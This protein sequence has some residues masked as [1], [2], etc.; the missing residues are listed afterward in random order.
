M[1]DI[2]NLFKY[3]KNLKLNI[4]NN[5]SNINNSKFYKNLKNIYDNL[6]DINVKI[7]EKHDLKKIH[8]KNEDFLLHILFKKLQKL[9]LLDSMFKFVPDLTKYNDFKNWYREHNYLI[10]FN[11]IENILIRSYDDELINLKDVIFTKDKIRK[12]LHDKLYSNS[13]VG[14][15]TYEEYECSDLIYEKYEE[16][17]LN[18]EIIKH[19]ND[20]KNYLKYILKIISF[21]RE[22]A[23]KYN[24][25]NG[26]LNII[27]FLGETSKKLKINSIN[28]K[29][30]SSDNVNSGSCY[31]ESSIII[32]RKEEFLKVLIHELIHFHH[33]DFGSRDNN[34]SKLKS[35]LDNN[36]KLNGMDAV[37]ESYTE[38]VTIVIHEYILSRL[39]KIDFNYLLELEIKFIYFQVCKI[40][41]YYNGKSMNDLFNIDF[42]QNTSI[43]SYY[44]IKYINL[45]N[46]NDFISLVDK[47][48][49]KITNNIDKYVEYLQIILKKKNYLCNESKDLIE[50]INFKKNYTFDNMKMT[51]FDIFSI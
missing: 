15:E 9:K 46:L 7:V 38:T 28:E 26:K 31:P 35:L 19:K 24:C 6:N 41:K 2:K 48:K 42:L 21:M 43:R 22:L 16:S 12:N 51:L 10:N 1:S 25:Y 33:I 49:L 36:F 29:L 40:I 18:L 4:D 32:W 37:N 13:F 20:N 11:N 47:T 50:K 8:D 34:Y 27:F 3:V 14:L 39:L 44:I 45:V 5:Y 30:I 17:K 23:N